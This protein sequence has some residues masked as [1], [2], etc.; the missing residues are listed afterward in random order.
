MWIWYECA[1]EDNFMENWIGGLANSLYVLI[2][3]A[4]VL[5][6]LQLMTILMLINEG[7]SGKSC[8]DPEENKGA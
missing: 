8:I 3:I 6:T 1:L 4:L 7:D 2:T 5:I